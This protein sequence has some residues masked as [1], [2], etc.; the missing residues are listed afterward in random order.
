MLPSGKRNVAGEEGLPTIKGR[1]IEAPS[2]SARAYTRILS[3]GGKARLRVKGIR[4]YITSLFVKRKDSIPENHLDTAIA[5]EYIKNESDYKDPGLERMTMVDTKPIRK[6]RT[7]HFE[8]A[9][10][11][12]GECN[13]K[14]DGH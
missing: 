11:N 12:P 2:L 3:I 14:G 6:E 9:P 8:D 5:D 4:P 7:S 13:F 1:K 10:T